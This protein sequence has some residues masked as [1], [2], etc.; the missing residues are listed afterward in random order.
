[1]I[2]KEKYEYRKYTDTKILYKNRLITVRFL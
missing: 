2:L 1:M